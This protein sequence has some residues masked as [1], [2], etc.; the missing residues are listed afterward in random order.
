[1]KNYASAL[2]LAILGLVAASAT[3]AE[4]LRLIDFEIEDQFENI[5]RRSD[6]LG[7]VVLLIGSDEDGSKFNVAWGESIHGSLGHHPQYDRISHL[8]HADLR[9]VPFFLKGFVR[10]M[11]PEN[12]DQWVLM[13][14]KGV[15]AETYKFVP[16]SS[17][18]LV[19]APD[20][21]LVHHAS[22]HE[23][24]DE[25]LRGL[26]SILRELLDEAQ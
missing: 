25:S 16:K 2:L 6:V 14:W 5:H 10:G 20:G 7:S 18:V 11:F 26:V 23:P 15:I 9:D 8:A 4:F 13:D 3:H 17:N 21:V 19:F 12:P 24:D 1:M 22:G